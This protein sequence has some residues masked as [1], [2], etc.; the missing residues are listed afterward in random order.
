MKKHTPGP[1]KISGKYKN[2]IDGPSGQ[3]IAEVMLS[4]IESDANLIAAAPDLLKQLVYMVEQFEILTLG[5]DGY[6]SLADLARTAIAKA[7]GKS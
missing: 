7:E 6:D 5:A 2:W 4:H 3:Q 1:W